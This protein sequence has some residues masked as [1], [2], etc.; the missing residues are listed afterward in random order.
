MKTKV[1]FKAKNDMS[2]AERTEA[3]VELF[4]RKGGRRPSLCIDRCMRLF[5]WDS[6]LTIREGWKTSARSW[7][8]L[9]WKISLPSPSPPPPCRVT[10]GDTGAP[11]SP[12]RLP[13]PSSPP[14]PPTARGPVGWSTG[15]DGGGGAL[16]L[17]R[18]QRAALA[19]VVWRQGIMGPDD[20]RGVM[21]TGGAHPPHGGAPSAATWLQACLTPLV[22]CGPRV[23]LWRRASAVV[24]SVLVAGH[25]GGASCRPQARG[26]WLLLGTMAVPSVGQAAADWIP[27]SSP[28]W[29][30]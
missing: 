1:F 22:P 3:K 20:E 30:S 12:A 10:L 18:W 23:G 15:G 19:A 5:Y 29:W 17:A 11:P 8:P 21:S 24:P 26:A 7:A 28:R 4:F 13:L 14:P 9:N 25:L 2:W 6:F 16:S 27:P